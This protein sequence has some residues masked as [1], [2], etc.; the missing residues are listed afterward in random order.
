MTQYVEISPLLDTKLNQ[1]VELQKKANAGVAQNVAIVEAVRH[2]L[3]QIVEI[4]QKAIAI[5]VVTKETI[6]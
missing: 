4:E 1:K 3:T 5:T 2:S 6:W